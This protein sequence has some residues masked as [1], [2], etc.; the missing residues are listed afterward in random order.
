MGDY[1]KIKIVEMK[2]MKNYLSNHPR[3]YWIQG[4]KVR[5]VAVD[6]K[7]KQEAGFCYADKRPNNFL[8]DDITDD[9]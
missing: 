4:W 2:D 9:F 8:T 6:M 7:E 5:E 3:G 1:T